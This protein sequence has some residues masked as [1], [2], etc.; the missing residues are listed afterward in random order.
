MLE[1][2]LK[3][4]LLAYFVRNWH[5]F[6]ISTRITIHDDHS[7]CIKNTSNSKLIFKHEV[8]SFLKLVTNARSHRKL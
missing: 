8:M 6:L 7:L 2:E 5:F 4:A 3:T 1:F